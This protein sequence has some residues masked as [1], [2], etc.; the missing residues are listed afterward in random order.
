MTISIKAL[1]ST[2]AAGLMAIAVGGAATS[3]YVLKTLSDFSM[4]WEDFS[5]SIENQE[6]D[7]L[8][9]DVDF[10]SFLV[11]GGSIATITT[12]FFVGAFFMWFTNRKIVS[13]MVRLTG[14]MDALAQGNIKV[15][16][17][18]E[19]RKDEIGIMA[20]AVSTMKESMII[21][22]SLEDRQRE[23]EET[24]RKMRAEEMQRVAA[25]LDSHITGISKSIARTA[26]NLDRIAASIHTAVVE[27]KNKSVQVSS[28]AGKA[29]DS[30]QNISSAAEKLSH[31]IADVARTINN[32]AS[33]AR[34]CANDAR[35]S[36][37]QIDN[38]QSAVD[39]IDGVIKAIN[40]IAEQTN[41]LA[42]NATIEA[43]RAGEA[44]KGFAVVAGEVKGLASETRR[45]TDDITD[46]VTTIKSIVGTTI[47]NMNRIIS[48]IGAVDDSAAQ[49]ASSID[50]QSAATS[51]ISH[52][53]RKTVDYTQD[54]SG[55]MEKI[56]DIADESVNVAESLQKTSETLLTESKNLERVLKEFLDRLNS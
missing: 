1:G 33:T 52:N 42:L 31:S 23:A 50:M 21:R 7:A 55:G 22:L 32:T 51:D 12:L 38:L 9:R 4:R 44:G 19:G 8:S 16:V 14:T 36:H 15:D 56:S 46:K 25:A 24:S 43:A 13:P 6:I 27:T 20:S 17:P 40:D 35:D 5:T 47:D 26:E 53:I 39:E 54:V 28:T 10:M 11:L 48:Q 49:V 41:L 34:S 37:G 3:A 29:S 2:V 18:F 45:M 30:V